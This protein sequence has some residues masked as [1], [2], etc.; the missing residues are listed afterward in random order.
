MAS[1]TPGSEPLPRQNKPCNGITE[2]LSRAAIASATVWFGKQ[3]CTVSK[4][5]NLLPLLSGINA[6]A[7]ADTVIGASTLGGTSTE[8]NDF[9]ETIRIV[10]GTTITS[11]FG[12]AVAEAALFYSGY[13][14]AHTC[15]RLLFCG[16]DRSKPANA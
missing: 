11:L 13:R 10:A 2:W 5:T 1:L 12:P 15:M 4:N 7:L 8:G 3:I 16:I 14:I 9:K 6:A